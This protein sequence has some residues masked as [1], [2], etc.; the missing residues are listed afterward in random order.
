MVIVDQIT[1]NDY[2]KGPMPI[3]Q[4]LARQGLVGVMTTNPAAG[5]LRTPNNTYATIGAG[6]KIGGGPA[7]GESLNAN[8]PYQNDFAG[9]EYYRRTGRQA[10]GGEVVHLGIVEME[11]A[12]IGLKYSFSLGALG[13]ILHQNELKTAVL[14]NA[15]PAPQEVFQHNNYQRQAAVIAMDVF[16]RVDYGDVSARTTRPD[17]GSLAG[18]VT[19]YDYLL[20]QFD[21]L[22]NK[23][24]LVVI[25]TGDTTRLNTLQYMASNKSI[26]HQKQKVLASADDFVGNLLQRLNLNRDLLMV[27]VPGPPGLAMT[28]GRFLT[29]FLMAGKGV[30]PGIAWSGT[31]KRD[32]LIDNTDI[33][34]SV[35]GHF[36]IP[37]EIKG[38]QDGKD[39]RLGGQIIK[40][41][42]HDRPVDDITGIEADAVFLHNARYPLVKGYIISELI[43]VGLAVSGLFLRRTIV[44]YTIPVLIGFT[45]VPGVML[46]ANYF[47]RSSIELLIL[48]I[49]AVTAGITWLALRIGRGYPLRPYLVT[50]GITALVVL[51]DI[52]V[53][54]PLAKTSPMSYDVMSGARYY[55]L[56][57]EYMGVVIGC[58]IAFS[59]LFLDML[60]SVTRIIRVT[61]VVV[62][63]AVVYIIAAPNLGTNVG[64]TIA[65]LAGLG[66]SGLIIFGGMVNKRFLLLICG[67]IVVV[68]G[69]FTIY[70]LNRAVEAQSHIGRTVLL[71]RENGFSEIADIISRKWKVNFRLILATS[72]SWFYFLS[73]FVILVLN[74]ILPHPMVEFRQQHPWFNR[75][76]AGVILGSVFALIFNDSGVVAAATMIIFAVAPY[77]TGIIVNS[78]R[79]KR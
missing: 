8:A 24:D 74:R 17:P 21:E 22:K 50:T 15:D 73:I 63:L 72:W 14:G 51:I 71:I 35:L 7:G 49:I 20:Q 78:G 34:A 13:T 29:P 62:F 2:L 37:A 70:D 77:L 33:A 5:R 65:A 38:K 69:C 55:G 23:A 66:A 76:L 68:L 3:M 43:I 47:P 46:W 44:K 59:G 12:N 39:I 60:K 16:G 4:K 28:E 41:K 32:G 36:G 67:G 56:G 26:Q 45:A 57:N 1:W 19:D 52:L 48:E 9:D 40:S 54:A 75:L 31:I 53:G 64:G 6:A 18:V 27:V 25:E 42:F 61:V 79:L 10:L 11:K 58:V 30:K